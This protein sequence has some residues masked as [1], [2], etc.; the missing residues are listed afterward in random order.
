MKLKWCKPFFAILMA[1]ASL[2]APHSVR[3]DFIVNGGFTNGLS[4]WSTN[5]SSAVTVSGGAATIYEDQSINSPAAVTLSQSFIIPSGAQSLVFKVVGLTTDPSE[6]AVLPAFFAADLVSTST[7]NSLVTAIPSSTDYYT[8]DLTPA[9]FSEIYASTGVAVNPL[10][11]VNPTTGSPITITL[12]LPSALSGESAELIF[13]VF[14]SSDM[15]QDSASI[16]ITAVSGNV[17]GPPSTVPEP[18]TFILAAIGGAAVLA[19]RA[20]RRKL[21]KQ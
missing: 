13:Y 14:P 18:S 3:A 11:V 12:G 2:A 15:S 5:D 17:S 4:G 10:N 19:G 6:N 9:P 8:R 21:S 1:A 20:S 16:S 7:G